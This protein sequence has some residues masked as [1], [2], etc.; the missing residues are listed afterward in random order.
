LFRFED[1]LTGEYLLYKS[2]CGIDFGVHL[3]RPG[4]ISLK[5]AVIIPV[6]FTALSIYTL[7][8]VTQPSALN[9]IIWIV[10]LLIGSFIGWMQIK[11]L[12]LKIDRERRLI[13]AEGNW[14]LLVILI[15]IFAVKYYFDYQ[16]A[17]T[18]QIIQHPLFV[19]SLIISS[20]LL[21]GWFIGRIGALFYRLFNDKSEDLSGYEQRDK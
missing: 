2:L 6:A 15:L 11:F 21:T 7:I 3:S 14:T 18:P 5:R 17:V 16:I 12:R 9:I 13:W 8:T 19:Y 10:T 4:F 1:L 20:A